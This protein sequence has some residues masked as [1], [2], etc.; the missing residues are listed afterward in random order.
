MSEN[1]LVKKP[2]PA[3]RRP[4]K[5]W[6]LGLLIVCLTALAVYLLFNSNKSVP[7]RE[8]VEQTFT[9]DT[10]LLEKQSFVPEIPMLGIIESTQQTLLRSRLNATV[11]SLYVF[12]GMAVNAGDPLLAFNATEAAAAFNQK[13]A[14]VTE[15]EAQIA[16]QRA[17]TEADRAS[18]KTEKRLLTLS[19]KSVTRQQSLAKSRVTSQE[20][21]EGAQIALAQQRLALINRQF[22]VD[23]SANLVKQLDARLARAKSALQVAQ[24]DFDQAELLA[25]FDARV[26]SVDISAG[27]RVNVSEPLLRLIGLDSLE[28]RAQIPNRWVP[29][30]QSALAESRSTGSGETTIAKTDASASIFGK[31]VSLR[32]KRIAASA[33]AGTG[34]VDAFYDFVGEA[35]FVLNKALAMTMRLQPIEDAYSVPETAIYGDDTVYL[36]QDMRMQP[37]RIT[38]LGRFSSERGT[39]QVIF[40]FDAASSQNNERFDWD[41]PLRVVTTQ[42]PKATTGQLVKLREEA[43]RDSGAAVSDAVRIEA[44]AETAVQ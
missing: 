34:G 25:P 2:E 13:Q 35:P 24:L 10:T 42:L 28:V 36:V 5:L 37:A 43:L 20:Q 21:L 39:E 41:E 19:E 32:L 9:V 11:Q 14:E 30:V 40:S 4:R 38:R 31:S 16:E 3:V 22:A 1:D 6:P 27:D 12:E 26:E 29:S 17:R 44:D 8:A 33:N 7:Q 23:N 18:L 15:L